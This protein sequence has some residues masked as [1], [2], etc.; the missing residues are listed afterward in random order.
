VTERI[1]PLARWGFDSG[2]R[3]IREIGTSMIEEPIVNDRS[4]IVLPQE[5]RNERVDWVLLLATLALFGLGM[6]MV[7]SST[8]FVAQTAH[9][10]PFGRF[11][12]QGM[13]G[14]IGLVG[15]VALTR[16]DYRRLS[17]WSPLIAIASAFLLVAVF[18]PGLGETSKG[19]QRWLGIGPFRFQPIEVARV[20][21]IIYLAR[22]LSKPQARISRFT[23]GPLPA[24][25]AAAVFMGLIVVQPS[26]GSTLT[27]AM[28]TLA[29]CL[30]AGM[31]RKHFLLVCL[32]GFL[33]LVTVLI[34]KHDSYQ[35]QRLL[36]FIKIWTDDPDRLGVTYQV[37]QSLLALGSGGFTG[38]GIGDSQQKRFFLPD[39]H[40]DFI[41][42]IIGEELGFVGTIGV[43]LL[44]VLLIGRGLKIAAQAEDRFGFLLAA[45]L[46]INF[47]IYATINMGVTMAL[48]PVTGLPLPFVSY[49][50]SALIANLL[51]V[52]ILLSISRRCGTSYALIPARRHR[53]GMA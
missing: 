22:L 49:G 10:D 53:R 16:L 19:S 18:I 43:L 14:I 27:M 40:T 33:A 30:T 52:G 11:L 29:M 45:G 26:L 34:I 42:S 20:G 36:G 24:F 48:L 44:F 32:G 39:A 35:V 13:R 41:F 51:A 4:A 6:L 5:M 3:V 8:S 17:D 23:T 50:G 21:L 38:V 15:L 28:T 2:R 31:K 46:T 47:M 7:M 1:I 9:K 12:S 25:L 37:R